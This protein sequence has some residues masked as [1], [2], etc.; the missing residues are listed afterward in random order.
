MNEEKLEEHNINARI[1]WNNFSRNLSS[2][3]VSDICQATS[4]LVFYGKNT[5]C[6]V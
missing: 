1:H 6:F 5:K 4:G 3:Y 2:S